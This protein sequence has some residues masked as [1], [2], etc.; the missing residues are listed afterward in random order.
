LSK[1]PL[2][3]RV[4]DSRRQF[5]NNRNMTA[6][7]TPY[8][9]QPCPQAGCSGVLRVEST[10]VRGDWRRRYFKCNT[11]GVAPA[12]NVQCVPLR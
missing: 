3:A 12:N 5:S 8:S 1:L 4:R 2:L 11:C 7:Y 9:G 6:A 10:R